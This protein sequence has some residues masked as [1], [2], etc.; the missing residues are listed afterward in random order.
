[1]KQRT[2]AL[3]H[4]APAAL[5]T[6]V[7]LTL[8]AHAGQAS[9]Q[10][11]GWQHSG[12][13]YL[14]TTPEGA[15]LPASASEDGFPLLVRLHRDFF[16]FGQAKPKGDDI[17]FSSGTG[18]PLA[19]QIDEWDAAAG[20]ASIW[21]RIPTIK[22]NAR[23]EIRM[24]WGKADAASESNGSAVFNADNGYV[25]VLHLDESLKDELGTLAPKDQGST[26]AT[27]LI[28]ECRQF[29]QGKGINCGSKITNY[30]YSDSPFTSEA[31][32]RAEPEAAGSM[33]LYWGRYATR[34]NGKTGDGNEVAI[35]IESPPR[36]GWGSDGP[37]GARAGTTLGM[38]QWTHVAAAY[39]EG[40]SR[41]YVNGM[42]AGSNYHKSAMSIVQDICMNIGGW[43]GGNYNFSGD[44][45]EVRVSRVA[46]SADWMRL[47]YENQNP[48][49]AL[50][51]PLVQKGTDFSVSAKTMTVLEG[52]SATVTAKA[53]GAQKVYWIL[54]KDSKEIIAAVDRFAFTLDAG[55][56]TADTSLTIQFKAVYPTET[57]T[58]DIPV[59]IKE[60]IP[61]PVV[62]LK[63][64]ATWDGRETI[65]VVPQIANLAEMQA[66]G[67]GQMKHTWTVSSIAVI[68]EIAPGKLILKRAQNSGKMTVTL[69]ANN[70]GADSIATA[71]ILVTEPRKDAWVRR[72]PGKDEKPEDD[73]FY[74]R[75]DENEG[76]LFYNGTLDH[77]ADAAFLKVYA[78]DKICK[79]ESRKLAADKTY[80]FTVK[81]KPG[82]IK[83]KVE[84]GVK[85]G[86][87]ETI[88]RTVSNLVCGDAYIIQGQS[89]AEATGPNNGPT[90]DP[91][92]PLNDWIRSYG[93]S[94]NGSI[95]GGWGNAIRTRIWGKPDYGLCQIGAWGMVLAE[96]LV[97]KYRI[98]VCI[99]NGAVGGTRIDQ[100]QRNE[101]NHNDPAT[102][103]GRLLTRIEG[104]RL[105]HGIRGVLWHQGENNQG[106]ASPTGDYDWKSYQQY[107]VDLSAAWKQDCPNIQHYYVWQIWPSGCNMGGTPAGDML[108]EVQR[109]LPSLFSNMRIMSTLGIVSKSSGRGLAHFDLEGYAQ[110]AQ[111]MSPLVEQDNYGLIPA[112]EITAPN[113]KRAWFTTAAKNEIA[114]DFGQPMAWKDACRAWIYLDGVAAPIG[115][116]KVA[117]NGITLQL[118]SPSAAK[119][120]SYLSGKHWDG[121]P[122]K[123]LYGTNGIAALALSAVPMEQ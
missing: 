93:N 7:A 12:S 86:G 55:R 22:G 103:Y 119:T 91:P 10:Y 77:A 53:G 36:L 37:G 57:R 92:T 30:P 16:D 90:V 85:A 9:A 114:L 51:G 112:R 47:Q 118:T 44:I 29:T 15:N 34:Y 6:L 76:T 110:I 11:P 48:R 27:G 109:T 84:F 120:I 74:A 31:W 87:T 26:R 4:V 67:A 73:Q 28:G 8:T 23:Q 40:T 75:D 107:F 1:M 64:P 14:L 59:A 78:D 66:R 5:L 113:L 70:G 96:N 2:T 45:D 56:V 111:L 72:T 46:R 33:I 95:R 116:G 102:I 121:R 100:H 43:R 104:A 39:T 13:L 62:T 98:P 81:L 17:R 115:A 88:L 24:Y 108:L 42:L 18:A 122:D 61:E 54:K 106:S 52:K 82:L 83:H 49:Q 80:A 38:R 101:A 79:T 19:Y 117:G 71:S 99:M 32:F 105:T 25:S 65:E 35:G 97:E 60:S 21:V 123:L 20:T 50:V 41:I 58:I 69:A 94:H 89:N 3:G 63:A 68:K